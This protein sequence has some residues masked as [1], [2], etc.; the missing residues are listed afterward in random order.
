MF[1]NNNINLGLDEQ[2]CFYLPLTKKILQILG[3]GK[4][5]NFHWFKAQVNSY[6]LQKLRD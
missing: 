4:L 6:F 2:F 1:P 5:K 3:G